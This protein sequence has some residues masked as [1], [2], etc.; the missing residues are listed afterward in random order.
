MVHYCVPDSLSPPSEP[1]DV[2][3][4]WNRI[5]SEYYRSLCQYFGG[6]TIQRHSSQSL[7]MRTTIRKTRMRRKIKTRR[8]TIKYFTFSEDL[9][10]IVFHHPTLIMNTTSR[11]R[12]T[13]Q[14]QLQLRTFFT[15]KDEA[16]WWSPSFKAVCS[17]FSFSQLSSCW[18]K[19]DNFSSTSFFTR[20]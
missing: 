12:R 19:E 4:T 6:S 9:K 16:F 13:T 7:H 17:S 1:A 5:N 3:Y 20:S 15:N 11:R 14:W 8:S 2:R 10:V 18:S